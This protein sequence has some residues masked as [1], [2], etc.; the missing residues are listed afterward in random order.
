MDICA[1]FKIRCS[2][3]QDRQLEKLVDVQSLTSD[4]WIQSKILISRGTQQRMKAGKMSQKISCGNKDLLFALLSVYFSAHLIFLLRK[5]QFKQAWFYQKLIRLLFLTILCFISGLITSAGAVGVYE[6]SSMIHC[7]LAIT[8]PL[9]REQN[10]NHVLFGFW[11]SGSITHDNRFL[12][13]RLCSR[14]SKLALSL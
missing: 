8:E 10:M 6:R 9:Q 12:H 3:E 4:I 14:R 7:M 1:D 11:Y 2:Q 13:I 5:L